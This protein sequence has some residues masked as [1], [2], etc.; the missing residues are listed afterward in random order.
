MVIRTFV[1]ATNQTKVTP[2]EKD[3]EVNVYVLRPLHPRHAHAPVCNT[4]EWEISEGT[5]HEYFE[6]L[7]YKTNVQTGPLI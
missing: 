5:L 3:Q 1:G 2:E 7:E 6:I 4:A